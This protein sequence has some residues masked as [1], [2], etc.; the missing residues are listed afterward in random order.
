MEL[1]HVFRRM[2]LSTLHTGSGRETS[3]IRDSTGVW[4]GVVTHPG[5]SAYLRGFYTVH[6]AS[7]QLNLTRAAPGAR[8][9]PCWYWMQLCPRP[10]KS[11][12]RRRRQRS[13]SW[14]HTWCTSA[15]RC[16][17]RPGF[18]SGRANRSRGTKTRRYSQQHSDC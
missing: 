7:D 15:S 6:L 14:I 10:G 1:L 17:Y 5:C 2:S 8:Q 3:A 12:G 18:Y 4:R 11:Y 16:P 9:C 13:P